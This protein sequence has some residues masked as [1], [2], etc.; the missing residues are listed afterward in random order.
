[1]RLPRAPGDIHDADAVL[2]V[3]P[4]QPVER[5]ERVANSSDTARVQHAQRDDLGVR[6]DAG[7][8]ARDEAGDERA[9]PARVE[10]ARV[11]VDEVD[12]CEHLAGELAVVVDAAVDDRDGH[13]GE[14][15]R[16]RQQAE[17]RSDE[18][19]LAATGRERAAGRDEAGGDD[20]AVGLDG[21]DHDV[22]G[23]RSCRRRVEARRDDVEAVE[24]AHVLRAGAAREVRDVRRLAVRHADDRVAVEGRVD[25][26]DLARRGRQRHRERDGDDR[27]EPRR[28]FPETHRGHS[29]HD[30]VPRVV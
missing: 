28:P 16:H 30:P 19:L 18:V 6:R 7:H 24:G 26:R 11:V 8:R 10:R 27:E 2:G 9:V 3:V 15:P 12:P 20:L 25:A 5:G 14:R 23:E 21:L 17:V 4:E 1:L 29:L 22:R 13:R